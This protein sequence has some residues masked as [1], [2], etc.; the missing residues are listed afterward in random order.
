MQLRHPGVQADEA[1]VV[2]AGVAVVAPDADRARRRRPVGGDEAALAAI[3][4]LVGLMLNT[5][6]SPKPPI[7][8]SP[9]ERAEGVGG[10]EDDRDAAL[11]AERVDV[12]DGARRAEHVRREHGAEAVL[13]RG[14]GR[15]RRRRA[16]TT[17]DRTRRRPDAARSTRTAWADAEKVKLGSTTGP[18]GSSAR[19]TS[20]SPAVHDDTATT[21]RTPSLAA[22]LASSS[23]T[24]GPFVSRPFSYDVS[25]RATTRSSAGSGGRTSGIPSGNAGVPPRT[26]SSLM[27]GPSPAPTRTRPG[28]ARVRGRRRCRGRRRRPRPSRAPRPAARPR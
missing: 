13:G 15:R 9:C 4:T 20:M 17:P 23:S 24:S 1:R 12:L 25:K 14:P 6:A 18:S 3:I 7:G 10:V 8:T 5:S 27:P 26:A 22:A 2:V 16:G 28:R 11:G 21:W 19:S